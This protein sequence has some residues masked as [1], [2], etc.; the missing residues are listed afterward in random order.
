MSSPIIISTV[1]VT[2]YIVT[3]YISCRLLFAAKFGKV[4][5]CLFIMAMN[6]TSQVHQI[7]I[8]DFP[9][10]QLTKAVLM[11]F[12][13]DEDIDMLKGKTVEFLQ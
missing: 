13:I 10:K 5:L 7:L 4:T 3:Y 12:S 2:Y 1:G 8:F 6:C 9:E 11:S